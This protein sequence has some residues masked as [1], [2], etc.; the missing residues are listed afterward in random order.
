MQ[1]SIGSF[2]SQQAV[3]QVPA[4]LRY[5][6]RFLA[7]LSFAAI[8][9]LLFLG[10]LAAQDAASWT[11]WV[12]LGLAVCLLIAPTVLG[13]QLFKYA[14]AKKHYAARQVIVVPDP[15]Q[16]PSDEAASGGAVYLANAA[17]Q[18]LAAAASEYARRDARH[19]PRVEA[20]QRA[21]KQ[22]AGDQF[23]APLL[24]QDWRV[25]ATAVAATVATIPFALFAALVTGV[26]LLLR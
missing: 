17:G 16:H 6:G 18:R 24:Q 8:G 19:L 14:R 1:S 9:L 12:P 2:A 25:G 22:L 11:S 10:V 26:N 4:P 15:A 20:A 7:L 5:P 23:D 3:S 21:A 13:W